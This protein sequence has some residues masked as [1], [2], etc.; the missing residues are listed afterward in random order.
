[1][2]PTDDDG[3]DIFDARITVDGIVDIVDS[4]C[5]RSMEY[6]GPPRDDKLFGVRKATVGRKLEH[7]PM[8]KHNNAQ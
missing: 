3:D 8:A 5:L 1:M 7:H 6:N 2:N 4:A